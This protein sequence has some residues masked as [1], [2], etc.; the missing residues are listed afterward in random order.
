M[1]RPNLA[2]VLLA[3]SCAVAAL[4]GEVQTEPG[5]QTLAPIVRTE[6][7]VGGVV[8]IVYDLEGPPGATFTVALEASND[9]GQ[10]FAIHPRAM[11]GDVGANVSP[12]LARSIEWDS[13]KDVDDL[14]IDRYVFRVL[15][16]RSGQAPRQ[17]GSAVGTLHIVTQPPGASVMIDGRARGQSPLTASNVSAGSHQVT[18]TKVGY[19][20]NRSTVEIVPDETKELTRTLTIARGGGKTDGA[21]THGGLSRGLIAALASGGAAA[22]VGIAL[23]TGGNGTSP[24]PPTGTPSGP[25]LAMTTLPVGAGIRDVT[26]F[27]FGES[28]GSLTSPTYTWDFGDGSTASGPT[29]THVYATEGALSVVLRAAAGSRVETASTTV[30]VGNI[31]GDWKQVISG[32]GNGSSPTLILVQQGQ[33]ITGTWRIDQLPGCTAGPNCTPGTFL[34]RLSGSITDPRHIIINQLEQCLNTYTA[35]V[36]VDLRTLTGRTVVNNPSCVAAGGSGG[37]PTFE[38]Q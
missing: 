10:T 17:T 19:L 36:S 14:Q 29:V 24:P 16:S 18:L 11:T 9:G 30:Q 21:K 27:T 38:R 37:T 13:T 4:K 23:A 20:E 26:M 7:G 34:Y 32:P 15:V 12:G 35:D 8:H 5:R 25:S 3:L 22:G 28:G 6:R 1:R 31:T 2:T 33:T